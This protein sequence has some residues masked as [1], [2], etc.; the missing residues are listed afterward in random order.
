MALLPSIATT[1]NSLNSVLSKPT[2]PKVSGLSLQSYC[3]PQEHKN[4]N[5]ENIQITTV[6]NIATNLNDSAGQAKYPSKT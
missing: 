6:L 3:F 2:K 5:M 1:F 4:N